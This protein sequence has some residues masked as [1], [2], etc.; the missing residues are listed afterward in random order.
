[1]NGTNL[2]KIALRALNNNKLR[3]FLTMLGIIYEHFLYLTNNHQGEVILA[4]LCD[5]VKTAELDRILLQGLTAR[6]PGLAIE[7][8]S[9]THLMC[10]RDRYHADQYV[11]PE[12]QYTTVHAVDGTAWY[13]QYAVDA[14]DKSPYMAPVSYTHLDVYKRQHLLWVELDNLILQSIFLR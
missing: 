4:L 1:M 8:V 13:K 12:G 3:A 6:Q 9:Y 11:A 7:P 14:V 10:I 5:P 2:F